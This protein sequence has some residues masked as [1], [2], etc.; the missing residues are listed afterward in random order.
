MQVTKRRILAS[1]AWLEEV[2]LVVVV[3]L[4]LPHSPRKWIRKG[5]ALLC[6]RRAKKSMS[7][8]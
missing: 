6:L 5:P 2:E 3:A 1:L 8:S 4:G 7:S